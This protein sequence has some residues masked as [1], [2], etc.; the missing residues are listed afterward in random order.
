MD[1]ITSTQVD[2]E[3]LQELAGKAA[4]V[5]ARA[6]SSMPSDKQNGGGEFSISDER[7][8]LVPGAGDIFIHH[9]SW[10]VDKCVVP[11]RGYTVA[12]DA[13]S[14]KWGRCGDK[15]PVGGR[16]QVRE[17]CHLGAGLVRCPKLRSTEGHR[18]PGRG[19]RLARRGWLR[20]SERSTG[21]SYLA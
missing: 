1:M 8:A 14:F 6:R 7:R 21:G 5:F 13:T 2:E 16:G 19:F 12:D 20:R 10:S 9:Q 17:N 11:I 18:S 3:R 15:H 4:I